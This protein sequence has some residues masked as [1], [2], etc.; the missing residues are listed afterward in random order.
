RR[1]ILAVSCGLVRALVVVLKVINYEVFTLYDRPYDP[2]GDTTQLGNGI[3]T[4]RSLV[5]GTETRLI[6][7]GAVVGAIAL[8]VLL[9]LSMLR[10]TRL[11]ADNRRWALR[12]VAGLA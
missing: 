5:G 3:E 7:V 1:R 6:E 10:L 11:A 4:L 9:T 2:L 8:G 12:A